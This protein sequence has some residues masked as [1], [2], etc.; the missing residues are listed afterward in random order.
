MPRRET[1]LPNKMTPKIAWTIYNPDP[2]AIS[3]KL[4]LNEL[5]DT[6]MLSR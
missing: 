6:W 4:V 3:I 5:I 1:K 2:K